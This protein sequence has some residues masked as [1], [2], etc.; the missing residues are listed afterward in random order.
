MRFAPVE[1]AAAKPLA[2]AG[3]AGAASERSLGVRLAR[4]AHRSLL[5]EVLLTPKPGLV[6]RRNCGAHR[7]MDLSSFLASARAIA[8][9]FR[10]FFE[11]G[12]EGCAMPAGLFLAGIRGDGM[13][14]ERAMLRATGGVNT[15]KGSIFAFGLLCAAAG[16]LAGRGAPVT[17]EPLCGEVAAVCAG[18]VEEL[19]RPGEAGTAGEHLF[20][21]HGLTGARGEAAS[22]FATVRSHALPVFE[23][24]R[25]AG[26]RLALHGALLEL[27]AVNPDTNVVS[28]GGL[29]GLDFLQGEAMRLRRAGG[30][31]AP[32]Y[33]RRL[34]ALDDE[35]IRRNL[36][37]GGSADLLAVTWF[38]AHLP[39]TAPCRKPGL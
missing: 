11:R 16:R 12:L 3:P 10:L 37:P 8:P 35:A 24:L 18:V 9:W 39:A 20:R 4:L 31:T 22:G 28:R 1:G 34:A 36:S 32:D 25:P 30:V 26:P 5:R 33:L 38:L 15:H 6:D 17:R 19:R 27:L 23:R 7:D 29:A 2:L 13:A 21:R 14:C